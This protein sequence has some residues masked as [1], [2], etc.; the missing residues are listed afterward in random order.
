[1]SETD[2]T[3]SICRAFGFLR[4]LDVYNPSTSVNKKRKSAW[5]MDEVIAE[6]VSLSP[7]LIS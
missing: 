4:G 3:T 6:R 2:V 1:M 7:N 5:I